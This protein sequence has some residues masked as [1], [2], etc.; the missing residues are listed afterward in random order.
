[1]TG[2]MKDPEKV[3]RVDDLL[4][5]RAKIDRMVDT[6]LC[7]T[8]ALPSWSRDKIRKSKEQA[9]ALDSAVQPRGRNQ[10][11]IIRSMAKSLRESAVVP[12]PKELDSS[13]RCAEARALTKVERPG[14]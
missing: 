1:M 7:N 5:V 8:A 14:G 3:V 4:L 2:P 12:L 13:L 9:N 10:D 11:E 6:F